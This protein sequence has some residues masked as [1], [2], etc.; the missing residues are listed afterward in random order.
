M[1]LLMLYLHPK[2][3]MGFMKHINTIIIVILKFFKSLEHLV[4]QFRI[5]YYLYKNYLKN[6]FFFKG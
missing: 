5:I 6:S 3:F 1:K 4:K 2:I